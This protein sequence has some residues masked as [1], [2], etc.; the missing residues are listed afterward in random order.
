[1]KMKV[2][3]IQNK[4]KN[5]AEIQNQN[6]NLAYLKSKVVQEKGVCQ[7]VLNLLRISWK[8]KKH[9]LAQQCN[10]TAK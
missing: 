8:E 2:K 5:G 9:F 3:L 7:P 10:N 4:N 1:M 6:E